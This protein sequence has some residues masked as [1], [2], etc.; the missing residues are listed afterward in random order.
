MILL[1]SYNG[2]QKFVMYLATDQNPIPPSATCL[3]FETM[4]YK[5]WSIYPLVCAPT[6]S[7]FNSIRVARDDER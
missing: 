6:Q 5:Q 3:H 1:N 7:R 4:Q 2:N